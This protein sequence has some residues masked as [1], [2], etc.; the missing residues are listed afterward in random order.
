MFQFFLTTHVTMCVC[1]ATLKGC[2]DNSLLINLFRY[3]SSC[4]F[5][6]THWYS[7]WTAGVMC[8]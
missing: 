8:F 7:S 1:H 4:K 2:L 3:R 6:H 5:W